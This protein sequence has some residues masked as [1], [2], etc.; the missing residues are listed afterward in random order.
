MCQARFAEMHMCVDHAG[1]YMK[2]GRLDR[3]ARL[4]GSD[5]ADGGHAPIAHAH[6]GGDQPAGGRHNPA[7]DHKI[8]GLGHR[9]LIGSAP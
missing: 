2:P 6:V 4:T 9:P 3:S 7:A 5:R 8:E 1:Q